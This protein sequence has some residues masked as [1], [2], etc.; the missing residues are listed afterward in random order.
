M[1]IAIRLGDMKQSVENIFQKMALGLAFLTK[2][3]QL[4]RIAFETRHILLGQIVK[5]G[6]MR[7]FFLRHRKNILESAYLVL[8]D[9]PLRA[10]EDGPTLTLTLA[11]VADTVRRR[12]QGESVV[13]VAAGERL[14]ERQALQALLLPSANNVAEILAR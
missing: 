4:A 6:D 14:T 7:G 10:G 9:H 8:R 3:G 13:S 11:D 1:D 12:A 5:P 2:S